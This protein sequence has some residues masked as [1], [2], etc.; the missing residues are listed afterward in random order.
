MFPNS[1]LIIVRTFAPPFVLVSEIFSHI[2]R[3]ENYYDIMTIS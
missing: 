2:K 1:L 3:V